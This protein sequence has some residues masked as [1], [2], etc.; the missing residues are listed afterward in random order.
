MYP[1]SGSVITCHKNQFIEGFFQITLQSCLSDIF[2]K[3]PYTS[4]NP[5]FTNHPL[6]YG[7]PLFKIILQIL[8]KTF[9]SFFVF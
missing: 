8:F 5:I 4:S 3:I 9:Q 1:V 2:T 6:Q 7:L